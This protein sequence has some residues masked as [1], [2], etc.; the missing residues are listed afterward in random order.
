MN[1]IFADLVYVVS[2][3]KN[4]S[5]ISGQLLRLGEWQ[6]A[7][8]QRSPHRDGKATLTSWRLSRESCGIRNAP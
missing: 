7:Q 6:Q 3:T 4:A 8:V 2:A 1:T 5:Q